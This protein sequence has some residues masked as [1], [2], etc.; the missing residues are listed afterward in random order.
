M[1]EGE[2]EAR[3][4]VRSTFKNFGK[5]AKGYSTNQ[6]EVYICFAFMVRMTGT[7]LI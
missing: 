1:T 2:E 4:G 6:K 5:G 7:Y 3:Q